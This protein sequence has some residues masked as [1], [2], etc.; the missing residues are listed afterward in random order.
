MN[1]PGVVN[2][3]RDGI[4]VCAG[5]RDPEACDHAGESWSSELGVRCT[6][7]GERL[8]AAPAVLARRSHNEIEEMYCLWKAAGWPFLNGWPRRYGSDRWVIVEHPLFAHVGGLPVRCDKL[9]AFT[10]GTP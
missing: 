9:S 3:A 7:C 1:I 6:Q 5:D 8:F 10:G 4:I 2:F